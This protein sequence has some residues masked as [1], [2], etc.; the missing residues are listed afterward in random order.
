MTL[1]DALR[2][3]EVRLRREL[4]EEPWECSCHFRTETWTEARAESA[5]IHA[6]AE[7][8]RD[9]EACVLGHALGGWHLELPLFLGVEDFADDVH[10][11]IWSACLR[12]AHRNGAVTEMSLLKALE[13]DA[14]ARARA[15]EILDRHIRHSDRWVWMMAGI[16]RQRALKRAQQA[17]RATRAS[18]G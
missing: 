18:R 13:G 9:P 15:C 3:R 11:V 10:R 7:Q 14:V 5:R 2:A 12:V 16:L 1:L 6:A 8:S 17:T 4:H